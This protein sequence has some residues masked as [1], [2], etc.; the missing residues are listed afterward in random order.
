VKKAAF[1]L[2]E[3]LLAMLIFSLLGVMVFVGFGA[4]VRSTGDA[5]EALDALHQGEAVL[6]PLVASL[7]SAAYYDSNPGLYAFKHEKGS[8]DPPDDVVSWVSGTLAFLPPNYPTRQ[9]L[10]RLVLSIEEIDGVRGLAVSAYPHRLSPDSEEVEEVE[11]WL[12]STRVKGLSVRYY[13]VTE[14]A[15]VDTWERDNQLPSTVE[16]RLWMEPL[17]EGEDMRELV[18][19]IDIP[20][21]RVSRETR[22]GRRQVEE[23]Q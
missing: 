14:Q 22:R 3:V 15:W 11:P 10:N 20:V 21:G 9:G 23:R 4:L 16:V 6:E 13:D 1:T 19:R 7:R 5:E 18:R 12:V 8:G 2:L 17:R